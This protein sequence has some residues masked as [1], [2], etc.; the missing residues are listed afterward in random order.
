MHRFACKPMHG[1]TLQKGVV[2]VICYRPEYVRRYPLSSE[3][4]L[5]DVEF[6]VDERIK[7]V[8]QQ[9][10][11]EFG[12]KEAFKNLDTNPVWLNKD[13]GICIRNVRLFTGLDGLIPLHKSKDGRTYSAKH[14][15][16]G[17]DV[18]YVSTRNNHHIAIYRDPEGKLCD[19]AVTFW[20]ALKRKG[21][22]LP[23]IIKNPKSVWDYILSKEII[24]NDIIEGLPKDNW[25]FV[26]SVQQNEMFVFGL[27]L[28]S[29]KQAV[30]QNDLALISQNLFRV[31]KMSKKSSGSIEIVF[32]NHL[33]T[34]VDDKKIGGEVISKDLGKVVFVKSLGKMTG[35]KVGIDRLGRLIKI[36][37]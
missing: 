13:K 20:D 11:E 1:L 21:L 17:K 31:Q 27:D 37:E 10:I 14:Y 29:L 9:R 7:A 8:V 22:G 26:T 16:T 6:I 3:F 36:G 4:K 23:I 33:E 19:N 12:G 32:R 25:E 34:S 24:E 28:P 18:D 2:T 30:L 15:T 35:I 5:K